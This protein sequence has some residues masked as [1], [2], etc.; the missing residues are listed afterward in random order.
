MVK[1]NDN[2][3]VRVLVLNVHQ[4]MHEY[5]RIKSQKHKPTVWFRY[6]DDIFFI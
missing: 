6:I 5:L 4:H 3:W 1:L 2:Y